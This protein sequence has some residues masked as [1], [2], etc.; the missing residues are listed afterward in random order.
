MKKWT[1]INLI[2][3]VLGIVC[4]GIGAVIGGSDWYYKRWTNPVSYDKGIDSREYN[5][6][7]IEIDIAFA[8]ID[9]C[10]GD[11]F[12]IVAENVPEE[13]KIDFNVNGSTLKISSAV[14]KAS[15]FKTHFSFGNF[16]N[17]GTYKLYIPYDMYED[18]N[19]TCA[20]SNV[21]MYDENFRGNF[22]NAEFDLSFS[23]VTC[24]NMNIT[25]S[26]KINSSFGSP[27]FNLSKDS[28]IKKLN[29]INSFGDVKINNAVITDEVRIDSSFGSLK[30]NLE[31]EYRY[32]KD[33]AFGRVSYS[34]FT[35]RDGT[36]IKI[37][38]AFG[39]VS[40]TVN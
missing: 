17:T 10:E 22:K 25:N 12:R 8:D 28:P 30:L 21:E 16:R 18:L 37:D 6:K 36:P 5:I 20:F 40:I 15:W 3:L 13:Y 14:V 7:N 29:I 11:E 23:N 33:N 19:F 34:G 4:L 35:S 24:N 2:A 26:L 32:N 27:L 38:N 1:F 9:I 39:D 31:G